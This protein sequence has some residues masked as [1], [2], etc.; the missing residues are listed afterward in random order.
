MIFSVF[1]I[2]LLRIY[3]IMKLTGRQKVFLK[4]FLD[5]YREGDEPLHYTTVAERLGIGKVTAYDM[6]RLLEEKGL[7]HSEYVLPPSRSGA[8][9]SSVV[10]RPTQ[11]AQQVLMEFAGDAWDQASWE[12]IKEN[13]LASLRKSEGNDYKELLE[14]ILLRLDEQSSPLVAAAEWV[15]AVTLSL[16]QLQED[17]FSSGW[18]ERLRDIGFPGELGLEALGGFAVGLSFVERINRRLIGRLLRHVQSY[19]ANLDRLTTLNR[20]RLA[21]FAQEVWKI[22][23]T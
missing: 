15:T 9:R 14:D 17:A 2:I 22:T 1:S 7:V 18:K 13:I 6:L 23:S 10:F 4:N 3:P 16:R 20:R 21:D 19:Q 12:E 5:L 8:G 11:Q